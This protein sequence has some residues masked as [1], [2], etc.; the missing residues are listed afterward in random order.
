RCRERAHDRGWDGGDVLLR[1]AGAT[2][3]EGQRQQLRLRTPRRR[4]GG[5]RLGRAPGER[6]RLL[7]WAADRA[8]R[9]VLGAGILLLRRTTGDEAGEDQRERQHATRI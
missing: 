8:P 4:A 6:A 1:R 3:A 9:R 5:I 7:G 2:G